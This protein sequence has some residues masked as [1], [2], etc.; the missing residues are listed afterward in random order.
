MIQDRSCDGIPSQRIN[1]HNVND[2]FVEN[3]IIADKYNYLDIRCIM[4]E[5]TVHQLEVLMGVGNFWSNIIF[6]S[7]ERSSILRTAC[8]NFTL[9]I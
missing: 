3:T 2:V 5:Q 8:M 4:L 6:S 1:S 7:K 9:A